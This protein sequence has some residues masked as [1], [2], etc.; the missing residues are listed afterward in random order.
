MFVNDFTITRIRFL[1][2]LLVSIDA[3]VCNSE[4]HVAKL[5]ICNADEL[6]AL[7]ESFIECRTAMCHISFRM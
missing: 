7:P 2:V 1:S 4:H 6:V 3:L 5:Q